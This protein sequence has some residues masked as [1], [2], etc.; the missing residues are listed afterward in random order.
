[1]SGSLDKSKPGSHALMESKRCKLNELNGRDHCFQPYRL[2]PT[3]EQLGSIH[4]NNRFE[5]E[6]VERSA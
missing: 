1:M 4:L 5:A 6:E 3:G 2:Q